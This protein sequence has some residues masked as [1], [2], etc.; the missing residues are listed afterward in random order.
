MEG[1]GQA[2]GIAGRGEGAWACLPEDKGAGTWGLQPGSGGHWDDK[3]PL[4]TVPERPAQ[5]MGEACGEVTMGK[6]KGVQEQL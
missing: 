2:N 6:T 5:D 3:G 1:G 4:R